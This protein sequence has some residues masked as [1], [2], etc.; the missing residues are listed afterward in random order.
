MLKDCLLRF[1]RKF[2]TN[3]AWLPGRPDFVF[4]RS[5]AAIFLDG[6]FWHGRQ[7][8]LRGLRSLG[9]QF[10]NTPNRSYWIKKI[11]ANIRRDARVNDQLRKM[12][13]RVVRVWESELKSNKEGCIVRIARVLRIQD[14]KS[15]R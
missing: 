14:G 11:T 12:G 3:V 15:C 7:W 10:R 13:W 9:S 4:P 2:E 5:R 6:D 1:R 8:R